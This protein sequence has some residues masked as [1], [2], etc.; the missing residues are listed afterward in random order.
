MARLVG[1][2]WVLNGTKA[3]ITNAWDASAV[4]VFATTD[5]SL[6]HK[7]GTPNGHLL[8]GS[9]PELHSHMWDFTTDHQKPER[10]ALGGQE[11]I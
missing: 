4:V 10:S 8:G 6:K 11:G 7:V 1:N 9:I 2:E 5:K 3:W